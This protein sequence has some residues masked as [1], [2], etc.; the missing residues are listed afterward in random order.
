[1]PRLGGGEAS[2]GA[3]IPRHWC[4]LVLIGG[5]RTVLQPDYL[6]AIEERRAGK[7]EQHRSRSPQ[8]VRVVAQLGGDA[9]LIMVGE[10]GHIGSAG[11]IGALHFLQFGGNALGGASEHA[12]DD[13]AAEREVEAQR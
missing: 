12:L 3:R 11:R 8:L 9:S 4:P 5:Y 13:L 10:E 1:M 2:A 7:R 6:P